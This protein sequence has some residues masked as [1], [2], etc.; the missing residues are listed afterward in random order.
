[1]LNVTS[2]PDIV[3]GIGTFGKN[4]RKTGMIAPKIRNV[5]KNPTERN[6]SGSFEYISTSVVL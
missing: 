1:M 5:I 4:T 6:A 3:Y 2:I